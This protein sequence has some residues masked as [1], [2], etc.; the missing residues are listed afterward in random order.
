M[1]ALWF[2]PVFRLAFET[3]VWIK[4]R[5]FLTRPIKSKMPEIIR[6]FKDY[7]LAFPCNPHDLRS[8][9][10]G[11]RLLFWADS[12]IV[13]AV[14]LLTAVMFWFTANSPQFQTFLEEVTPEKIVE[15]QKLPL[16]EQQ[17][18]FSE[19]LPLDE[20]RPPL[21]L[22]SLFFLFGVLMNIVGT[23][24]CMNCPPIPGAKSY[25]LAWFGVCILNGIPFLSTFIPLFYL[26]AWQYWLSFFFRLS[27]LLGE[28]R[29]L[30]LLRQI[31][32]TVFFMIFS[33]LL[34]T[35]LSSFLFLL[36]LGFFVLGFFQYAKVLKLLRIKIDEQTQFWDYGND[37]FHTKKLA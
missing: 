19:V 17:Q 32:R 16:L 31:H 25:G 5:D 9:A 2:F 7:S 22:V 23:I 21:T 33:L 14:L 24:F 20:L 34:A 10:I 30:L 3:L 37:D 26:L 11:F 15:I 12:L 35:L 29:V 1:G 6:D 4:S 8:C 36:V 28:K 27:L 18:Y 13:C